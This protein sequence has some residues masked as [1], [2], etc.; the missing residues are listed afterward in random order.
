VLTGG[1]GV[2]FSIDAT[3]IPEVLAQ[4]VYSTAP[5]GVCGLI[6][7]PRFGTEVSLDVNELLAR[8]RTLHGIVEGESVPRVF[9]PRLIELWRQG[10]FPIERIMREYPFADIERAV[11]DTERG[12]VIKPVLRMD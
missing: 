12:E 8:G 2:D 6:G 9:L 7:A 1:L 11:G 10:R 4:A 3:G 5:G